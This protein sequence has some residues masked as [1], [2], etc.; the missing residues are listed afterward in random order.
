MAAATPRQGDM[1]IFSRR[2]GKREATI[3]LRRLACP[4][5]GSTRTELGWMDRVARTSGHWC[6]DCGYAWK[7]SDVEAEQI[8]AEA[9]PTRNALRY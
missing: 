4:A 3:D 6:D 7:S 5:C 2:A 1:G 9:E 8:D